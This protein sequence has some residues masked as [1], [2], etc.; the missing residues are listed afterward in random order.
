MKRLFSLILALALLAGATAALAEDDRIAITASYI[1][2]GTANDDAVNRLILDKFGIDIEMTGLSFSSYV[3]ETQIMAS[4]GT[5]LDWM[6][7]EFNYPTYLSWIDQELIK[8]M[9]DGWED[10]YPNI[11]KAMDASGIRDALTVDGKVYALPE[12]VYYNYIT[13][14]VALSHTG[15]FYRADWLEQLG[16]EPWGVNVTISELLE[17]CRAAKEADLAGNG[18]TIGLSGGKSM[19]VDQLM[20]IENSKYSTFEKQGGQYVW[21]PATEVVPKGIRFIKQL[22]ADGVIN[23]DFYLETNGSQARFDFTSGNAAAFIGG[24]NPSNVI[25]F[26]I[27]DARTTG[28]AESVG[29]ANLVND[30]G[31]WCGSQAGNY[32]QTNIFAPSLS[33]EKFERLL[34][35]IDWLYTLEAEEI[36]NMGI[37]GVD[38][39]RNT[40]GGYTILS[41]YPSIREKYTS[42]NFWYCRTIAE[43]EFGLVSPSADQELLK[44]INAVYDARSES[45][46]IHGYSALDYDFQFFA[47]EA[48]S[49]YSVKIVDEATRIIVDESIT[50]DGVDGEWQKVVDAYRNMWE[51]LLV[52]L[53][54]EFGE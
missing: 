40:E 7:V 52:E 10:K 44:K 6:T 51:P 22:Y 20:Y 15:V 53:N 50:L 11:L 38:W 18:K 35:M 12:V 2:F 1:E 31:K 47:S 39:E 23:P 45:A 14:G 32:W 26:V 42:L 4:G 43:D 5:L 24:T 37:E 36:M 49:N 25:E 9:P 3:N 21:V 41:E 17:F 54:N 30:E 48:K 8:P 19:I 28:I 16:M 34:E 27:A 46:R 29:I 33:D 13:G